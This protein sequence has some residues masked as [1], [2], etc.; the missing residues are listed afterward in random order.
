MIRVA[1]ALVALALVAA[2]AVSAERPEAFVERVIGDAWSAFRAGSDLIG[3]DTIGRYFEPELARKILETSAEFGADP[4]LNAQDA[5]DVGAIAAR[6]LGETEGK[7]RVEATWT[8]G[9]SP[10]KAVYTVVET[11][12]GWRVYDIEYWMITPEDY[13]FQLELE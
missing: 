8:N 1:A 9:G 11:P 12:A 10:Q 2:P 3:P 5:S 6:V 13:L 4:I 7:V